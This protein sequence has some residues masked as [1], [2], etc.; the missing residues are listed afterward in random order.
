MPEDKND[1]FP[2]KPTD[3]RTSHQDCCWTP[4]GTV[5]DEDET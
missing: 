4:A 2:Q 3:N 1:I 5:I